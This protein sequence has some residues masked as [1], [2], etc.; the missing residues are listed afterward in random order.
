MTP[1]LRSQ[2]SRLREW[3]SRLRFLLSRRAQS[4]QADLDEELQFHL[5]QSIDRK[6][7]AG[8]TAKQAQREAALEFGGLEQA[9]EET[10]RQRPGWFLETLRQDVRYAMRGFGRNPAFT[11]TVLLTLALGI[12]ATTA[13]F[14]V[15][16]RILFRALPYAQG[17]RLVSVGL[18]A[19][20]LPEE[21]LLGGSYFVWRDNQVPFEA[22][23]SETGVSP[24][25]LTERSPARLSCASVEANFLPTLGVT[26]LLGRN[27]LPEEDRPHGPKA[28]LIS[29]G[30]WRDRYGSDPAILNRLIEID[31]T[32]TRVIGVLPRD[33]EMPTLEAADVLLPQ[34][35]DEAAERKADPGRVMYGFARLK[36]GVTAL[37]AQAALD[38][39]FQYSLKLVP[40]GFRN[41]VHL[42]V[43]T[44]RDRQMKGVRLSAWVLLGAGLAVLLIGCG[45]V[46]GLMLARGMTREREI[47]VRSA[48]GASRGRLVRQTLTEAMLLS[49]AGALLGWALAEAL[50]RIFVAIAPAGLPF[51]G[52]ARL[53]L[54]IVAFTTVLAIC[55]GLLFGALAAFERPRSLSAASRPSLSGRGAMLRRTLVTAEI[56]IGLILLSASSLL[57]RSFWNLERQDLGMSTHAILTAS[58]VLGQARYATAQQ[59]MQFFT[60]A[61]A[62]LRRLPGVTRV[63]VSDS[64][65][66]S[67]A[68][69]ESIFER[70]VVAG[71]AQSAG[72]ADGAGGTGGMVAWRWVTPEYFRALQIP[73]EQGRAFTE[74]DRNSPQRL[75]ILSKL[76]ADR[77]FPGQGPIGQRIRPATEDQEYTVVGVAANVRNSGLSG[78]NEPEYYRLRRNV[79]ED[80]GSSSVLLVEA[81]GPAG[82]LSPWVRSQIGGIDPIVPVDVGTL[83]QSVNRLADGPRFQAALLGFFALSGLAMAVIGLYG[84]TTYVAARRTQE[85]GVRMALGADRLG[86]LRLIAFDGIGMILMGIGIGLAAALALTQLLRSLLFGISPTDPLTFVGTALLLGSVALAATLIPAR[87]AMRVDPAVALRNE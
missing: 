2:R 80:W 8:L 81:S 84:L 76:L 50:V 53:D 55:C 34:A 43:R 20:I 36:P 38:P 64:L 69:R 22:I 52:Q 46:A 19:P 82:L 61:E 70:L 12:G 13:V 37:R 31:G 75:M 29:Y 24:C 57:I 78:S 6:I 51:L 85:I 74:S 35:L 17:D 27:F 33:F 7:A 86:I 16:D 21:F 72:V 48:L 30:L 44:L 11:I 65:P 68:H 4:D 73:I 14:S 23:T 45:N 62:A 83:S 32:A 59:Q 56:A 25:D 1:S 40:P 71:R 67:G 63:A 28:L 60:D 79:A 42:R 15:V 9:R 10:Y 49:L 54:R 58:V 3:A 5:R 87:T 47:A 26:P 77:L 66:P 41:E 18:T 39:L